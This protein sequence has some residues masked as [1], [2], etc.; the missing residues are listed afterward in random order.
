MVYLIICR[1]FEANFGGAKVRNRIAWRQEIEDFWL[2]DSVKYKN[3]DGDIPEV[4]A[5]LA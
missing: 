4:Q 1:I 5:K 2:D 3:T